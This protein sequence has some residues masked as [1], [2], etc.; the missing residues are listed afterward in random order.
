[1]TDNECLERNKAVND[2]PYEFVQAGGYFGPKFTAVFFFENVFWRVVIPIVY[3]T[4]S[5]DIMRSL[6]AMPAN[7][8]QH[9][10]QNARSREDFKAHWADCIDYDQGRNC[11]MM[12]PP[13]DPATDL[14]TSADRD[15]LSTIADLSQHEPNSNAMHNARL[16][17]EKALKAFLCF[18]HGFS[19][20]MVKKQF[21]HDLEGLAGEVVARDPQ[22]EL[23]QLQPEVRGFAPYS[24]R[25]ANKEYSRP[26][27]WAAYRRA[28]FAA[29]S[30]MRVLT[31]YNQ[32][33][34]MGSQAGFPQR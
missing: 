15:L 25:Y 12:Q 29:S 16:S 19:V 7:L 11:F 20:E 10:L 32:R 1:M 17:T 26:E 27:L 13:N 34:A 30:L 3:G 2:V 4:P 21:Q 5:V 6:V 9:L 31:L 28:Q 8:Q 18:R 22:S 14:V 33:S 24:D 23:A